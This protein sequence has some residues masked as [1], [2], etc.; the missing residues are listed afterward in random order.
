MAP[1]PGRSVAKPV[2]LAPTVLDLFSG[3]GGMALGFKAA[4]ARCMG[5]VD[6][7]PVAALTFRQAFR[8]DAPV[9]FG[10]QAGKGNPGGDMTRMPPGYLLERLPCTPDIV[11]G[12]PPCQS[13]SLVGRAKLRSLLT[14]EEYR[15]GGGRERNELYQLFLELVVA[16]RPKAFVMENVPALRGTLGVDIA[17]RIAED[18]ERR[19]DHLY[20]VRYFLLNAAWYGVPQQRWRVFFVGLRRDLGPG[21]VPRP[22]ERTHQPTDDFPEGMAFPE[23]HHMIPGDKIPVSRRAQPV[24]TVWQALQDLPRLVADSQARPSH[25]ERLPL[26]REP[27]EWAAALRTWPGLPGGDG[28]NGNWYRSTPRDT[29]IF[30]RMA[31]GDRYPQAL[32]VAEALFRERLESLRAEGKVL[33]PGRQVYQRLRRDCI[34]PYRNDA[35]MDKWAKLDP[36]RPSWTLTAHLSKDSYSHIHY[37]SNQAR[38]ITIREAARLQSFPDGFEFCGSPGDQFRQIGNAVPPLVARALAR[39]LLD[40]IAALENPGAGRRISKQHPE[41]L[42]A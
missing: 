12:G 10:G 28:V 42:L 37:D 20:E 6:L 17:Q 15:R 1:L 26:R 21:A 19:S 38:T 25:D 9:V 16:A 13:F 8:E 7:D 34:P 33:L 41:R 35:F 31:H 2:T 18:A 14:E 30:R 40:Q 23:D 32:A 5:A 27:S 39:N 3:A 36:D 22:P 11:V 29:E 24:V 4:G